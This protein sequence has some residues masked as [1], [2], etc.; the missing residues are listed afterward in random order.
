MK[1]LLSVFLIFILCFAL[2]A[3][4][5]P[6]DDGLEEIENPMTVY[7]SFIDSPDDDLEVKGLKPIEKTEFYAEEGSSVFEATQV[8]CINNNLDYQLSADGTYLNSML[9]FTGGDF[10]K[11]AGWLYTVNGEMAMVSA[12]DYILEEGDEIVW[13][14][15]KGM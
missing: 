14:F 13:A 2:G 3:C 11:M 9:G 1:K 6:S 8:F 12:S 7:I 10:D 15:Q 4:G 5:A